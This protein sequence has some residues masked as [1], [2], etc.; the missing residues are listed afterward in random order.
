MT[1]FNMA[2]NPQ[3]KIEWLEVVLV[4]ISIENQGYEICM[5]L[6]K[7]AKKKG[8]PIGYTLLYISFK[9]WNTVLM[10]DSGAGVDKI[11]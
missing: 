2:D 6:K 4:S 8:R 9:F 10:S 5:C 1:S 3:Q 11:R 7:K